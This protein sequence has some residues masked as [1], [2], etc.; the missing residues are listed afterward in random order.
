MFSWK[1]MA[2]NK[3]KSK[4]AKKNNNSDY[5]KI[6]IL[7]KEEPKLNEIHKN[8]SYPK[9][10]INYKYKYKYKYLKSKTINY[11]SS[12][13]K[14]SFDNILVE[15]I[16]VNGMLI[17]VPKNYNFQKI[18]NKIN[19]N[20]DARTFLCIKY[21]R[22]EGK[23]YIKFRNIYFYNYY[24]YYL[25]N[26]PFINGQPEMKL[27]KVENNINIWDI[28]PKYEEIKYF[29]IVKENYSYDFYNNYIKELKFSHSLI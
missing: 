4:N 17:N 27:C 29:K 1:K 10:S 12:A 22:K 5:T 21:N 9:N 13:V 25:H 28:N 18:I 26:R 23:L 20:C 7:I 15:Y 14:A 8:K 19:V 6:N 16:P 11:D 2:F 24:Y 3:R